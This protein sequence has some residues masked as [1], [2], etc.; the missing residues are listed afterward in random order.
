M[1]VFY[2]NEWTK[3]TF[4]L[5]LE[6]SRHAVSVMRYEVGDTIQIID[7]KGHIIEGEIIDAHPKKTLI[8]YRSHALSTE[9]ASSLHIAIS[10]TKSNE[11]FEIFIEKACEIGIGHITPLYCDRTF[12]K[13]VNI[14]RWNK[15]IV[16]ACKQSKQLYFP[17]LYPL[18]KFDK[19]VS[20]QPSGLISCT[21]AS[22]MMNRELKDEHSTILIGPEGDFSEEEMARALASG[23]QRISLGK[24]ILRVETAGIVAACQ[25]GYL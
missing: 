1:Q 23:Y 24:S 14:D 9:T 21:N 5:S 17:T 7:G 18:I 2:S 13:K 11:R 10:P 8:Q 3:S 22:E 4:F 25:W 15:I 6:E 16:S 20:Q 19:F 12:R